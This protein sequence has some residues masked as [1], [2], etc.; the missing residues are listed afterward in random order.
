MPA[1]VLGDPARLS[2]VL[3]NLVDNALKF[4]QEGDVYISVH[5]ASANDSQCRL[6]FQV[7]DTGIGIAARRS[8]GCSTLRAGTAPSPAR[9]VGP[10][11]DWPSAVSWCA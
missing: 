6:R 9:A 7:S 1:Q 4:T 5:L 10:G 2:Q 3:S 11:W 8:G